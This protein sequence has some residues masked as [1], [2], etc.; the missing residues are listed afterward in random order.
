[1]IQPKKDVI[2]PAT[3][4]SINGQSV[5][6]NSE[7]NYVLTQNF[8]QYKGIEASTDAIAKGFTYIDDY[9]DEALDG[10]SMQVQSI[11]AANGDDVSQLF[12]MYH[13]LSQDALDEK[14]QV[15]VKESGI[16][17]VGEFYM[18]VA[19]NPQDFYKAYVQKGLDITYNLSFKIKDTFKEGDITNGTYQ[20]DFGNGYYSN[21]V[22]N[23]LPKMEVHKDV[24]DKQDGKSI[25]NGTVGLGEEATYRLLR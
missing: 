12:E 15:I 9:L 13:V 25:N 21:I 1:M 19:K 23:N 6:P 14:L 11:K 22:V 18:W 7:L 17:P 3:G 24:L 5:L 10:K 8:D 2:D 4:K 16:S 20:I